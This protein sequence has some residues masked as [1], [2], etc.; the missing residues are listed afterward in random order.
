VTFR[1]ILRRSGWVLRLSAALLCSAA[2]GIL[3]ACGNQQETPPVDSTAAEGRASG[4]SAAAAP[5]TI[6]W[7]AVDSAMGRA[8]TEQPGGVHRYGIPRSDLKVT[9]RGVPI[10]PGFAL[11]T[12]L[13]VLPTGGNEAVVMGDLVLTEAE[14]DTVIAKLQQSGIEQTASHKHLIDETPRIWWTHVHA[15]GDPVSIARSVREALA[16]SATPLGAPAP[17]AAPAEAIA[18]D[19]AQIDQIFGTA[20]KNNGGIYQVSVPRAE[21]IRMRGVTL[22]A[23]MGL[24]NAINFQPS[25]GG[26]AAVNGDFVMIASEVNAVLRAIEENGLEVVELHNHLLDEEP[27]LFFVHFWGDGD[28]VTLARGLKAVL[29]KTNSAKGR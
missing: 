18:I 25:G 12:Y 1:S 26:R 8:G 19:T 5:S 9:S 20:G 17:A 15:H 29:D 14:R 24:A 10:R 4:D 21:A 6:D 23:S 27:R 7:A 16:L 22:P 3:T 2:S 11:G 13:V 28:A